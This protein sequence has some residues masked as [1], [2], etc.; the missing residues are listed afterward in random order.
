MAG[1]SPG[2]AQLLLGTVAAAAG[3]VLGPVT[4]LLTVLLPELVEMRGVAG[5]EVVF[6]EL[7]GSSAR[8][9]RA[10]A[11]C[12]ECGTVSHL[13]PDFLQASEPWAGGRFLG[14][15]RLL[16]RCTPYSWRKPQGEGQHRSE[17]GTLQNKKP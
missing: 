10:A 16:G 14:Q 13:A 5:R 12:K 7:P 8:V 15:K 4:G 11:G 17:V 2:P 1:S 6:A 3:P 9:Q